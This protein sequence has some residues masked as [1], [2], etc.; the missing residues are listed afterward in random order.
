MDLDLVLSRLDK[1]KS[2]GTDKYM[3]C[4]PA[5]NDKSPSMSVRQVDDRVLIHCFAGCG[6]NE[7]LDSIGLDYSS[8]YPE[9]NEFKPVKQ[10]GKPK[11]TDDIY[12]NVYK[13]K[14][15]NGEKPTEQDTQNYRDA[16]KRRHF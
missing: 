14:V 16:V 9:D 1:V 10:Y 13:F 12:I 4:C 11:A 8:L 15:K 2:N 6:A 5:H 7:I 3:A